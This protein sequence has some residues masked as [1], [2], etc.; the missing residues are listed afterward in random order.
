MAE[1]PYK[2]GLL[3]VDIS[4]LWQVFSFLLFPFPFN[5]LGE[6]M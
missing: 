6:K 2:K 1:G 3:L 5:V 4:Y